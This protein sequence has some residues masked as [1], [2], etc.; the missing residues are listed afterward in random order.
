MADHMRLLMAALACRV[1]PQDAELVALRIGQN[2]PSE[3]RPVAPVV[4]HARAQREDPLD[5]CV[6]VAVRRTEAD[7]LAI[8]HRLVLRDSEEEEPPAVGSTKTALVVGALLG[9]IVWHCEVGQQM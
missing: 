4:D 1:T 9:F 7:V 5:L 6:T 3:V 8:L 2:R